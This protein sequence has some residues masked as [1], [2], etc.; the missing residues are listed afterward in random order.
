MSQI[1]MPDGDHTAIRVLYCGRVCQLSATAVLQHSATSRAIHLLDASRQ[2]GREKSNASLLVKASRTEMTAVANHAAFGGQP[3]VTAP[4]S[5]SSCDEKG[6]ANALPVL[7]R[8][9]HGL[10]CKTW[11][12]QNCSC[13]CSSGV[14]TRSLP[15]RSPLS[16]FREQNRPEAVQDLL[17]PRKESR[18]MTVPNRPRPRPSPT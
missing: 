3:S 11:S 12:H 16:P 5:F 18:E 14:S 2:M 6:I 17:F 1:Q 7:C 4:I 8:M 15:L 10:L 9:R 13:S